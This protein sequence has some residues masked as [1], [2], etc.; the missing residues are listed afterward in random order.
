MK[1]ASLPL[2]AI[3][4]PVY[5]G[6]NF[7]AE[8]MECVQAQTYPNIVHLVLDNASTDETPDIIGRFTDRRVPVVVTRNDATLPILDNWNAA[9]RLVPRTAAYF[10]VLPHDDLIAPDGIEKMVAVGELNPDVGIMGCQEWANGV[11]LGRELPRDRTVFD[12]RGIVRGSLLNAIHGFPHLH[13]L[14]RIRPGGLPERFYETEFHGNR[15][16]AVDMD[17]AMRTLAAGRYGYVHEP[18]VTTRLHDGSVTSREV[19]PNHLKMWSE[20]QLIDRWGPVVFDRYDDYLRCRTRHLRFY[21]RYLLLWRAQRKHQLYERHM[22]WLRH[23]LAEPTI[24]LYTAAILEW[25]AVYATR[26]LK[27]AAV[28]A[29]VLSC[30]FTLS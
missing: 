10:R 12:G 24:G 2:V 30:P 22:T 3:V 8:T 15:L 5:N 17:A 25:P 21:Y 27:D 28:N 9:V 18:L 16:L 11:V 13:C 6:A 14:Y 1:A 19:A 20:L 7:L 26:H 29:G 23:A 4:T